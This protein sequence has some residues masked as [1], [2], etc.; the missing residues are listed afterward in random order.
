MK[1]INRILLSSRRR[2]FRLY[3]SPVI[4]IGFFDDDSVS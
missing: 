1:K 3:A 4:V 2:P